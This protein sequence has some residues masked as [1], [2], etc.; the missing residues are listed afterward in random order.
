MTVNSCTSL[1]TRD[2]ALCEPVKARRSEVANNS[3]EK[4]PPK[5]VAERA[6]QIEMGGS[7][8]DCLPALK[9]VR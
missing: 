2:A 3:G 9:R 5:G 6:L 4:S 7:L 1:R 8:G